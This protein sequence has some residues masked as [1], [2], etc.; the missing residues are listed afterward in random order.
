MYPPETSCSYFQP[1]R[2]NKN[3]PLVEYISHRLKKHPWSVDTWGGYLAINM[4]SV[5]FHTHRDPLL[6]KWFEVFAIRNH[7]H[8]C[9]QHN[10]H[11]YGGR[12]H[13]RPNKQMINHWVD[14]GDTLSCKV[15]ASSRLPLLMYSVNREVVTLN[16][17]KRAILATDM[18]TIYTHS[19]LSKN[20]ALLSTQTWTEYNN[21]LWWLAALCHVI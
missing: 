17:H 3:D 5:N 11:S 18:T 16:F 1:F 19:N 21:H 9:A 12:L 6:Q 10:L 15:L 4:A 2:V 14:G 13:W 8:R 7:P 20:K